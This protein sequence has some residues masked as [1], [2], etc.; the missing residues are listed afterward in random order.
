MQQYKLYDQ[1]IHKL[2][3]ICPKEDIGMYIGKQTTTYLQY[4][5]NKVIIHHSFSPLN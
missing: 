5:L 2:T 3:R 1:Q 4:S